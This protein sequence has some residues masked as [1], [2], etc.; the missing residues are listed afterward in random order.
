MFE[1]AWSAALQRE[2]IDRFHMTDYESRKI[3]PYNSWSTKKHVSFLIELIG[4]IEGTAAVSRAVTLD[5][6]AYEGLPDAQRLTIGH[7]YKFCGALCLMSL[8]RT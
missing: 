5:L 6:S 2:G 1:P 8:S 7:P 3:A 4:I